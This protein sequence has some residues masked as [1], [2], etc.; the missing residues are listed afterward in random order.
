MKSILPL[1]LLAAAL[2]VPLRAETLTYPDLVDRLYDLQHL[3]TPP[4]PG[5]KGEL[6]SSYDRASKYDAATDKYLNWG[7][8]G[9]G[10]FGGDQNRTMEGDKVVL[11]DVQG[12]GCIWR[13]WSATPGDGH[14][15]IYLDGATTPV[16]DLPFTGY[17]D[18]KTEPFTRPQIVYQTK[19]NGFDN[20]TPIS[21][22]KSCKILADPNW[23]NYYHFNYT[24]FSP[25]TKVETFSLP[26]SAANAAAL[27]KANAVFDKC[28]DDPHAPRDGEKTETIPFTVPAGTHG[29]VVQF[30]GTGA[31][32]GLRVKFADGVLP[33]EIEA[34]RNFLRQ[35][36]LRV[37]FDGAK[38]P[39]VWVPF[40][41]FFGNSA[42]AVPHL[43]LPTG[44]KDD[45]TWYSYWY[46]PFGKGA[47]VSIDNDSDK[48]VKLNWEIVHAPLEKSPASLLRFHAKWHRDAF[49]PTRPDR[50]PDWTLLVT[51]GKGRYVG[52]QLHVWNPMG[53]WWGEG[54]E[55]W[56]IDGEKMP[57]TIG[58]GSEDYFGYAWSSGGTFVQALHAQD[59]NDGNQGHVS[60]NRFHIADN[61]PFHTQFE[62]IIEKYMPN[63]RPTLYAATAFWYLNATGTDPYQPVP[64]KQRYGY[65]YRPYT[66]VE[67]GVIE[68]ESL[69]TLGTPVHGAG[70]QEMSGFGGT[71]WSNNNQLF[72]S[73]TAVGE[74]ID[75]GFNVDKAGK[76]NVLVRL[77]RAG[78]Y[79]IH[80]LSVNDQKAG[81]PIDSFS[82]TGVTIGDP[83]SIGT[84]D[85]PA[86]QNKLTVEVT[87]KNAAASSY[88]FGLDYVKL[89]PAP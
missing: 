76:Y 61:L 89:V 16:V 33:T 82:S 86:G 2:V 4:G 71:G 83:V 7:A 65:W 31:I 37:T 63:E 88:L 27:D 58:T 50:Q 56:F 77:T 62:G 18:R 5:E 59:Y 73:P 35:L 10:N 67:P 21:F 38:E 60:V 22:Q 79:G 57:S 34:Q 72:W 46:M 75:L 8:N 84:F 15:R 28:G 47:T 26:L 74:K 51:Q 41:D 55:K 40:G 44:L 32:T 52:T 43:E 49:L 30:K 13:T 17:F 39:D 24:R 48:D 64:V 12:P 68:G 87:G 19:A 85:L 54:D 11:M 81:D 25:D 78:D 6:A 45:G 69:Q 70:G 36:A 66:Y 3:A 80:Q 23:G 29:D 20:F 9:D 14:V 1:L 42:G 53:G